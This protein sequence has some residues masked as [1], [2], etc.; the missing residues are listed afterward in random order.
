MRR[1]PKSEFKPRAFEFLRFVEEQG[2]TLVVTDHGRDSVRIEPAVEMH[3]SAAGAL[4]GS[5]LRYDSPEE[6]INQG[7]WETLG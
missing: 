1:I 2:E 6:P 7:D 3:R 5:L 4:E